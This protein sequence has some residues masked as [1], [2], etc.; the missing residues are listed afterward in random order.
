[1]KGVFVSK[2]L[3]HWVSLFLAT[4]E[5]ERGK[6][7]T[8][9]PANKKSWSRWRLRDEWCRVSR[10]RALVRIVKLSLSSSATRW[11]SGREV[12]HAR[13]IRPC[14][15]SSRDE[16]RGH[17]GAAVLLTSQTHAMLCQQRGRFN[18]VELLLLL[19]RM[20][21]LLCPSLHAHFF[22]GI[23]LVQPIPLAEIHAIAS[24]SPV[25]L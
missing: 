2:L 14:V 6:T 7:K 10:S 19:L 11:C 1:M 3:L 8:K 24:G 16:P 5:D 18:L 22:F 17:G 20:L 9:K 13:T 25:C 12:L 4:P 15:Y 21:L 23:F